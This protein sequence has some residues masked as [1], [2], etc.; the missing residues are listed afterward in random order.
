M[1]EQETI[2]AAI[3]LVRASGGSMPLKF[4][5]DQVL[6]VLHPPVTIGANIYVVNG[7]PNHGDIVVGTDGRR[8]RVEAL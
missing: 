3:D 2:S 8:F 1:T 5:Y 6:E 7:Q 4:A